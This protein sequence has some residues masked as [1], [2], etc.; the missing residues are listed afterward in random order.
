M[1][2]EKK[3]APV[4]DDWV[5]RMIDS[6]GRSGQL[7]TGEHRTHYLEWG[8]RS[9]PRVLLLLH[10]FRGH[11]HWWD[12]IAPWFADDYRVIAIDFA[13]M[14]DSSSR[15][16]YT[17]ATFVA[18]VQA[19]IEMTGSKTVTLIGHSFGG[20]VAV[21]AAHQCPQLLERALVIDSNIGFADQTTRHRFAPR[22]KK[23]YSDL[24]TAC[25]RFRFIPDEPPI[26]PRIM[27]H[28]AVHSIKRQGD[29]FVWK[30][31]EALLSNI[32]WEQVAEGELLK[33]M[34]VPVDFI[35]GEFSAV[36]PPELAQR[37]GKALRNGRGPIVIP[38]AYHHVPVD[39]PLALVA[40][41]RA[42]LS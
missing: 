32:D 26:L 31:D 1:S 8:D 28:L 21:L 36:V 15:L 16:K 42:L 10:G 30:Y 18:E 5:Q 40:A 38:S 12:F 35:A 19:I 37:I 2:P 34:Q 39:Q 41:M 4:A 11:A 6:P 3:T 25:D 24:E 14:G 23:V 29:G 22:P 17:R 33:E 27:R 7:M 13:G 9:N 20:R